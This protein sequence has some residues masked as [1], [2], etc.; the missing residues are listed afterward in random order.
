MYILL[1]TKIGRTSI[2][3]RN[4]TRDRYDG[5]RGVQLFTYMTKCEISTAEPVMTHQFLLTSYCTSFVN[6]NDQSCLLKLCITIRLSVTE[7][8]RRNQFPK[9]SGT[10]VWTGVKCFIQR[11][12]M[13][14]F[15]HDH[16]WDSTALCLPSRTAR[17]YRVGQS[18]PISRVAPSIRGV[19]G[20]TDTTSFAC[21]GN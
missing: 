6:H 10:S 9:H 16:H 18:F 21:T 20:L 11:C 1:R 17:S 15:G 5:Y 12:Q 2:L 4:V 8:N 19:I 7:K 13:F 14:I 3:T